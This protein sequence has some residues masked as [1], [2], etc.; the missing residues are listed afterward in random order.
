MFI[1]ETKPINY[2]RLPLERHIFV[3]ATNHLSWGL[4][5]PTKILTRETQLR[6]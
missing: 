1:M 6:F 4:R 3:D 2:D 5:I